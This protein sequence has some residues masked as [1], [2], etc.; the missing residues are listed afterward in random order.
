MGKFSK[1]GYYSNTSALLNSAGNA[2]VKLTTP[3]VYTHVNL[4]FACSVAATASSTAVN[5]LAWWDGVKT[6]I[7]HSGEYK[8]MFNQ[9][10]LRELANYADGEG[11]AVEYNQPSAGDATAETVAFRA[12]IPIGAV[13]VDGKE[14]LRIYMEWPLES[15]TA[16]V[17]SNSVVN[18]SVS[19]EGIDAE[20]GAIVL[21]R[22]ALVLSSSAPVPL[23]LSDDNIIEA[24]IIDHNSYVSS[25]QCADTGLDDTREGLLV[26]TMSDR[27]ISTASS[28]TAG[29]TYAYFGTKLKL[30]ER[31]LVAASAM[32]NMTF[33]VQGA[34]S[35]GT[36]VALVKYLMRHPT[37]AY[38]SA[39]K[40]A[41]KRKG[42]HQ[43]FVGKKPHQ[44]AV[45][46]ATGHVAGGA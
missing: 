42:E 45:L 18:I 15:G 10:T 20:Q 1:R 23:N 31:D 41:T 32:P 3:G 25:V 21:R 2:E 44:A 7:E 14:H 28:A 27:D 33:Q 17:K 4:T 43:I 6:T 24:F 35:T 8:V 16:S 9:C 22:E 26:A 29:E 34:S 37:R 11:G 36:V 39:H 12:S 19:N 40:A 30:F 5:K 13:E 46:H 38:M